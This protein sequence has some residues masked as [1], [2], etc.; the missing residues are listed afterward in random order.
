MKC[1]EQGDSRKDHRRAHHELAEDAPEEH[2][3]LKDRRHCK[4][5]EHYRKH[6]DV[7]DAEQ[8]RDH[9]AAEKVQR[10][11]LPRCRPGISA[12]PSEVDAEIEEQRKA[13]PSAAPRQC[14]AHF[15]LMRLAMKDTQVEREHRQDKGTEASPPK[16]LDCHNWRE[17]VT[18]TVSGHQYLILPRCWIFSCSKTIKLEH[19]SRKVARSPRKSCIRS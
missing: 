5:G 3:V 13:N 15:R 6:E 19:Y 16:Q 1:V 7:I 14:L 11:L 8:R 17:N 9:G 10:C 2:F 4:I 12:D 18:A